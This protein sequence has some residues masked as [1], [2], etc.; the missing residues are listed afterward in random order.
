MLNNY[1]RFLKKIDSKNVRGK[2]EED[3]LTAGEHKQKDLWMT[4]I[5]SMLKEKCSLLVK[6]SKSLGFDHIVMEDLG[7]FGK[8]FAKNE[9]LEGFK[10]S[11]LV[12]LLKLSNLNNYVRSI[13]QKAG[14]QLTL[15]PSHYTSQ[16]CS[17]C[18]TIDRENRST[19][20][21]FV[22]IECSSSNNADYNSSINIH[23]IGQYEVEN[24][25]KVSSSLLKEDKSKWFVPKSLFKEQ[26][27]KHLETIVIS[28]VFQQN[29][30][31]L[32]GS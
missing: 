22:C 24:D 4:R 32:V 14:L 13:V 31:K 29:R 21:S 18:G 7:V 19:Q 10:Y 12:K 28:F 27:R 1:V 26:I 16:L 15:I 25:S 17:K 6:Q 30:L 20:E 2:K 9:S 3:C 11:R 5:H 23:L 8:G